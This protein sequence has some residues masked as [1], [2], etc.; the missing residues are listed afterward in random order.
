MDQ[1]LRDLFHVPLRVELAKVF[2]RFVGRQVVGSQRQPE[3]RHGHH[4]ISQARSDRGEG[5]VQVRRHVG[6]GLA[7]FPSGRQSEGHPGLGDRL[8]HRGEG[9]CRDPQLL[10]TLVEVLTRYGPLIQQA[11]AALEVARAGERGLLT[12]QGS[13][14]GPQLGDLGIDLFGGVL[15]FPALVAELGH[16]AAGLRL[17]RR[18]AHLRLVDSGALDRHLH[19]ERFLVELDEQIPLLHATVVVDQHLH[20]LARHPGGHKGRVTVDVLPLVLTVFSAVSTC[21]ARK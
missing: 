15:E 12:P 17:G 14:L 16:Q 8:L 7:H 18:Q 5:L 4:G 2:D 19:L 11:L 6:E 10:L 21:G 20:H 1:I 3:L 13:H 9:T